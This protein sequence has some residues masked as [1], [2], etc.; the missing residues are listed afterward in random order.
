MPVG[1]SGQVKTNAVIFLQPGKVVIDEVSLPEPT[2]RDIVIQT[3]VSGIS[4][5]TERWAYLG[6][7]AEIQFPNVPGYMGVGTIV[8]SGRVAQERGWREGNR[9]YYFTS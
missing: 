3:E 1:Y 5:G 8:A 7:R 4:V 9:A 2:P 6:K